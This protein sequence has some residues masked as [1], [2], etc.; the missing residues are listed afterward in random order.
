MATS[1]I[2]ATVRLDSPSVIKSFIDS[3][4]EHVESS[5]DVSRITPNHIVSSPDAIKELFKNKFSKKK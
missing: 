1:S 2:F 4:D 5:S 3:Y